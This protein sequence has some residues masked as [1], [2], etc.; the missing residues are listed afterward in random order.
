MEQVALDVL[1]VRLVARDRP[2]AVGPGLVRGCD[3]AQ[4]VRAQVVRA[5]AL[6]AMPLD[7][8][9]DVGRRDVAAG[10]R[11]PPAD[12]AVA[13]LAAAC[14]RRPPSILIGF[15]P[16]LYAPVRGPRDRRVHTGGVA[17]PTPARSA[18]VHA[19]EREQRALDVERRLAPA[20]GGHAVAAQRPVAGDDPVARDEQPDRVAADRRR[21]PR[22]PRR[23]GRCAGPPR[24]SWRPRPAGSS[25]RPRAPAGPTPTGRRGRSGRRRGRPARRRGTPRRGRAPARR[26]PARGP[27]RPH[28]SARSTPGAAARGPPRTRRRSTA[29]PRRRGPAGRRRSGRV[30]TGC[31]R[32]RAR[33]NGRRASPSKNGCTPRRHRADSASHVAHARRLRLE[34]EALAALPGGSGPGALTARER[35]TTEPPGPEAPRGRGHHRVCRGFCDSRTSGT[36]G[37]PRKDDRRCSS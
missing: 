24:R 31:R 22:A 4:A 11:E 35:R 6:V 18:E 26:G 16:A 14:S 7:V 5:A 12:D 37:S 1:A 29:S 17:Q 2:E 13:C 36:R 32:S 9:V 34:E 30:P 15:V 20:P 3:Q 28:R 27:A 23:C 10:A 33:A 8:V 21:R 19:L 25:A